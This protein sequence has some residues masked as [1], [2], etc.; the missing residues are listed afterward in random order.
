MYDC[1]D[2]ATTGDELEAFNQRINERDD[3]VKNAQKN[4][5]K[6]ESEF[7]DEFSRL[8]SVSLDGY[9]THLWKPEADEAMS[10]EEKLRLRV[11]EK[12][13]MEILGIKVVSEEFREIRR[14]HD[15]RW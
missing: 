5:R 15:G 10:K 13:I 2:G 11:E 14:S 7:L 6:E 1:T 12:A 9:Y 3:P 8:E 4:L